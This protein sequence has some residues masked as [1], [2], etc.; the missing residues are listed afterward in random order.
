M[1][2]G[3]MFR[4]R[5]FALLAELRPQQKDLVQDIGLQPLLE[6]MA[7]DD[8]LVFQ[9]AQAALV[10]SFGVDTDTARYRQ[11][12]LRDVIEHPDLIKEIYHLT[13]AALEGRRKHYFGVLANYPSGTLRMSIEITRV[14]VEILHKLRDIADVHAS[15]FHSEGFAAMLM[16]LQTEFS[17]A[18]FA[19]IEQHLKDLELPRG[20]LVSAKLG[21]ANEGVD[22]VLRMPKDAHDSWLNRLLRK[23]PPSYTFRVAERDEAGF[24]A[25]SELRDRGL[26]LT[27]NAL[28]QS[29]EHILSF[30]EVLRLELAFYIG[31]LNLRERLLAIGAQI[32]F[33]EVQDRGV[34]TCHFAELYDV[35]LAL[36]MGHAIVGNTVD[37]GGAPLV[38]ITGANQ[39][40]KSSFLRSIGLAQVMMQSGM[41]VAAQSFAGE[42]CRS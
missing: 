15:T 40:G 5:D 37:T 41:F 26:D 27:A 23:G 12:I 13:A 10:G 30:F 34:G 2:V 17:D 32:V 42:L 25:L 21:T 31:C 3:L 36:S 9:A 28:A 19:Q 8:S 16:M 11:D 14:F 18:Y 22:Y 20:V 1:K 7:G 39:G 38:I 33:P 6:S 4:D 29:A 35:S 24:R